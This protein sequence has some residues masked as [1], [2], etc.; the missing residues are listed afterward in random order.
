MASVLYQNRC[1]GLYCGRMLI[2]PET[3]ETSLSWSDCGACPR[4]YRVSAISE[5]SQCFP[6]E[7]NPT[8][9][10]WMYLGF[11]GCLPLILHWFFIDLAAKERWSVTNN[12]LLPQYNLRSCLSFPSN[13][14]TKS[15][16]IL[17]GSAFAEVAI[18]AIATILMYEPLW[19]FQIYSCEV[20]RLADWYTLFHNP[21]PNY[22]EKLHCTQE[23]V[24]P[25]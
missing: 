24:F 20:T 6:C 22:E 11:M 15:E 12:S 19:S 17:H 1:P 5:F 25:L 9:Y 13:S 7:S 21:T 2:I 3:N 4:G 10:D 14:F 8:T 16:L 18:S 23:A